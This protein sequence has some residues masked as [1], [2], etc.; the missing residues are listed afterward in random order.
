MSNSWSTSSQPDFVCTLGRRKTVSTK[1]PGQDFVHRVAQKL[2]NSW[3]IP[4]QLPIPWEVAGVFLAI[5]LWQHPT[6]QPRMSSEAANRPITDISGK[7]REFSRHFED[8][9]LL[10]QYLGTSHSQPSSSDQKKIKPPTSNGHFAWV[11]P[12]IF[13]IFVDFR[14]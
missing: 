5:V 13:V 14:V 1:S 9:G 8:N 6:V 2:L 11:T 10:S 4:R 7:L 3:S 12:A